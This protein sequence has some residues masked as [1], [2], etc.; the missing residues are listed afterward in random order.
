M[1]VICDVADTLKEEN[2]T[3]YSEYRPVGGYCQCPN[4]KVYMVGAYDND[5]SKIACFGGV[6]SSCFHEGFSN[7]KGYGVLCGSPKSAV[8]LP[9]ETDNNLLMKLVI[10][11][12][13]E[14]FDVS[15]EP[16]PRG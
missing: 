6:W 13:Q 15:K 12:G 5:C 4:G 16:T 9:P 3:R 8:S 14:T 10:P 2:P 7:Y 11:K 1:G